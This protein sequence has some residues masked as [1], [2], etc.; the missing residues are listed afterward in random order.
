MTL[1]VDVRNLTFR[2][3]TANLFARPSLMRRWPSFLSRVPAPSGGDRETVCKPDE[4]AALAGMDFQVESGSFHGLIGPNG[5][6]KST[7]LNI[8]A[9]TLHLGR[10]SLGDVR[11]LGL[12]PSASELRRL[13]SYV[14]QGI[15]L[16]PSLTG[17]EN[18]LLFAGLQ[19]LNRR[20]AQ[21]ASD[22]LIA[23]VGLQSA[24]LKPVST[25]SEGMKRRLNLAVGIIHQPQL[26]ILDE[27]TAG[28]DPQS[29]E[30]I[31]QLLRDLHSQGTTIILSTH[32]L[33]EPERVCNVVSIVD[34]GRCIAQRQPGAQRLDGSGAWLRQTFFDLTGTAYREESA[35]A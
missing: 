17:A 26:L 30:R 18:M 23:S 31:L 7:L 15:A 34:S 5:A 2:Y 20:E 28:V 32:L 27:P 22:T 3:K 29:R 11:V 12:P 10:D 16:F 13:M 24:A 1:A 8:I 6:G 21:A 25:Y 9:G 33:E 14:P 4:T 35:R 19:G